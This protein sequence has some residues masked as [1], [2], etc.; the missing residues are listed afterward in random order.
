M[1]KGSYIYSTLFA[2]DY[3]RFNYNKWL[4]K[5]DIFGAC[6]KVIFD[7]ITTDS[8]TPHKSIFINIYMKINPKELKLIS[9]GL[10]V[11]WDGTAE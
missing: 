11:Q 6:V 9:K 3:N 1:D 4:E 10:K 8:C 7:A 5:L 2:A